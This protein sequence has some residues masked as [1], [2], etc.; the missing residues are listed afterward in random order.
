MLPNCVILC[1]TS[2]I[3]IKVRGTIYPLREQKKSSVIHMI[4]T[5]ATTAFAIPQQVMAY[6]HHHH[7]NHKSIRVNQ[8]VNQANQCSGQSADMQEWVL[9]TPVMV[10]IGAPVIIWISRRE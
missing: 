4:D 6:R 3:R 10:K 5:L 8:Q 1:F 2:N 9:P 7:N